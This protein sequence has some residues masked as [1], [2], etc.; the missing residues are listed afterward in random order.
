M[1]NLNKVIL[2]GRLTRDVETRTFNNGGKVAKFGFAVNNRKK[3]QQSGSWEDEPVY[4]DCEAFNRGEM[5]KLADTIEKFC[6]KGSQICIEGHLALD[7]WN[8]KTTGEKRSK[9]KIV[10]DAMQLLDGRQS[11][12]GGG[13]E[14]YSSG[15]SPS[16]ASAPRS[17]SGFSS[18][19]DDSDG[20]APSHSGGGDD[21]VPF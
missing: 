14:G 20:P 18:R 8:D 9:L 3:N 12:G 2:I 11:D 21:E 7:N 10:V 17:G 15:S 4:L 6:R 16:R 19:P 1:A 13:S 5:G